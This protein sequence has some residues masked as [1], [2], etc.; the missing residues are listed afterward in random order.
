MGVAL[1][2]SIERSEPWPRSS[3]P[4]RSDVP[5]REA[6]DQWT[7][8]ESFPQFMEGVESVRQLDDTHLHWVATVGGPAPGV[9]RRDHRAGPGPADHLALDHA[10]TR[11]PAPSTF[12]RVGEERTRVTLTMGVEPSNPSSGSARRSA[13]RRRQVKGDLE[14]FKA[15]IESRGAATGAWRGEVSQG[16][17]VRSDAGC[18]ARP[19]GTGPAGGRDRSTPRPA[20]PRPPSSRRRPLCVR[21]SQRAVAPLQRDG[22]APR[23]RWAG[24]TRV[25][26][27]RPAAHLLESLDLDH[28]LR[29]S[30]RPAAH[31]DAEPAP[32]RTSSPPASHDA[33]AHLV[34]AGFDVV[35]LGPAGAASPELPA[36]VRRAD[37]LPEHLD[38]D[39][40][41]L[42]GDPHPPF[43]RPRGGTTVLVGPRRPV[44]KVPTPRFDMETRDLSAAAMEILS[45]DAMA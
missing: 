41:Y 22:P 38:A 7:Q 8:F 27:R 35:L 44:G 2:A 23:V 9:G 45:R 33:I 24:R 6:Y 26:S 4:S 36:A 32:P 3:T 21:G 29:R 34:E 5:V 14:R 31:P 25:T 42:T 1:S 20:T 15:F 40:W 39:A 43:G 17:V 16:D 19:S 12:Q 28:D 11:T 30:R 18:R 10:G 37:E 13:S